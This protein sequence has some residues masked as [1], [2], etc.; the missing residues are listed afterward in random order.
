MTNLAEIVLPSGTETVRAG[1]IPG[2]LAE[3][4]HPPT[5]DGTR[6]FLRSLLKQ[7]KDK[8]DSM[9]L[10]LTDDDWSALHR[11]WGGLPSYHEG[12]R[13]WELEPYLDAI[14]N[15]E[16]EFGWSLVTVWRDDDLNNAIARVAAEE[17]YRKVLEK[18][19]REGELLVRSRLTLAPEPF[20][21][22]EQ[23]KRA[24]VTVEDLEQYA[25]RFKVGVRIAEQPPLETAYEQQAAAKRAAGRY[26]LEE[27]AREL[28][29][30][31]GERASEMLKKL[32]E[33]VESR[34]LPVYEPGRRARY[35]PKTI[36]PFY[37]ETHWDDLNTWLD[38]N[39][40]R[41]EWRFPRPAT[42]AREGGA[43]S[44]AEKF[45]RAGLGRKEVLAADWPL[46]GA[47]SQTSLDRAL[48]EPPKW[49]LPARIAKGQAGKMS[50][51]WN[52]ALIADCLVEVGHA[53]KLALTGFIR[54]HFPD[55]LAE[56][57]EYM[58]LR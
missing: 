28:E 13:D 18:A 57:E 55:W 15:T 49:L 47:F 42:A 35:F 17:E 48:S 10:P 7:A 37:E 26:T 52:P 20:P 34:T 19:V 56:W 54:N 30:E 25:A 44:G 3:A 27:A 1:D 31:T 9:P 51:T 11:I 46:F 33:A 43:E 21:C 53:K 40:K 29:K 4:V 41:V 38:Q 23:L 50:S 14:E 36:R 39:E 16:Q 58:A 32:I 45:S 8:P 2:L 24:M 12:M 22:G 5:P 6:R